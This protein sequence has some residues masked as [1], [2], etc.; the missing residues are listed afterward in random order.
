MSQLQD[1]YAGYGFTYPNAYIKLY[2]NGA[3]CVHM[4]YIKRD[5]EYPEALAYQVEKV[6]RTALE[7]YPCFADKSVSMRCESGYL[8]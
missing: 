1:E 3:L 5:R 6:I 7:K 4:G 2:V 8:L